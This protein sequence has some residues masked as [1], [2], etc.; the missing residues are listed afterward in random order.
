MAWPGTEAWFRQPGPWDSAGFA[1]GPPVGFSNKPSQ[2]RNSLR[3]G[4]RQQTSVVDAGGLAPVRSASG[5]LHGSR[6]SSTAITRV[7]HP[8]SKPVHARTGCRLPPCPA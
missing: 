2:A 3:F 4:S 6:L 5:A 7:G 8:L 1:F